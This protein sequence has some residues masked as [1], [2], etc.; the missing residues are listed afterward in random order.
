[1]AHDRMACLMVMAEKLGYGPHYGRLVAGTT[2]EERDK[3]AE[4]GRRYLEKRD[5]LATAAA[6]RRREKQEKE[7]DWKWKSSP[8]MRFM[9]E[10]NDGN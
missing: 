4:Q 8:G 7:F 5:N 2:P 10:A 6:K 1:M 3:L 9:K